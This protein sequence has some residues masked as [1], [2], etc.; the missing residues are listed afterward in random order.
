[1][2]RQERVESLSF[3]TC[4]RDIDSPIRLHS[5]G[6]ARTGE[7]LLPSRV[8]LSRNNPDVLLDLLD[9][10]ECWLLNL[11][12]GTTEHPDSGIRRVSGSHD[13]GEGG[14]VHLRQEK[15]VADKM[16]KMFLRVNIPPVITSA[17]VSGTGTDNKE[18]NSATYWMK[19]MN[20]S[21][22]CPE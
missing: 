7:I 10:L 21:F 9:E 2:T 12:G 11:C 4:L 19:P 5:E 15:D 14:D 3:S 1:M 13:D 8:P 20:A 18:P 6:A 22:L 17:A 16:F